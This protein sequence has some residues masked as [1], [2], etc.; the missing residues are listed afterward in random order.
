MNL[1]YT[2]HNFAKTGQIIKTVSVSVYLDEDKLEVHILDYTKVKPTFTKITKGTH[3]VKWGLDKTI[4]GI[5][6]NEVGE[7][8]PPFRNA[9]K[10]YHFLK[11]K[12]SLV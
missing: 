3:I 7:D 9:H 5:L 4:Q 1:I 8:L 11:L 10:A 2:C 6:R 12:E